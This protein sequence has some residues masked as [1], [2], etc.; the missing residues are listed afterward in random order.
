[1]SFF[2]IPVSGELKLNDKS[3]V[4]SYLQRN[5]GVTLRNQQDAN[6]IM[7]IKDPAAFIELRNAKINAMF[8]VEST[9]GGVKIEPSNEIVD[10]F[11]KQLERYQ[12]AGLSE[13]IAREMATRSTARLYQEELDYYDMLNPGAYN[14]AFGVASLDHNNTMAKDVLSN[15]EAVKQYKA[16]KKA[17]K[18]AKKQAKQ[19]KTTQ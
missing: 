4:T 5:L 12:K 1:M 17:K 3:T 8:G 10:H 13:D 9:V 15:D 2:N 16:R 14:K 11:A 6:T 19:V 7:A 18:H